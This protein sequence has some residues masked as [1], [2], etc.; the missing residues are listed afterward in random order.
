VDQASAS[1]GETVHNLLA[2]NC[3]HHVAHALN[4]AG[5][6]R[7]WRWWQWPARTWGPVSL[8]LALALHSRYVSAGRLL[9]TWLPF[10]LIVAGA[11]LLAIAVLGTSL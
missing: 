1:Y 2:N 4:A 7:P 9:K 8:V 10:A 11:V 5:V 3:H 6:P